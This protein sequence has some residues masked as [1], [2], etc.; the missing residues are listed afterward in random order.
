VENA[1]IDEQLKGVEPK[2][3]YKIEFDTLNHLVKVSPR[4]GKWDSTVLAVPLSEMESVHPEFQNSSKNVEM[5]RTLPLT[6]WGLDFLEFCL[7]G[8]KNLLHVSLR[9]QADCFLIWQLP[10][11]SVSLLFQTGHD[12]K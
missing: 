5:I 3:N 6:P 10:G 8:P 4:V 1:K 12:K 7:R 11:Q 9:K 2:H